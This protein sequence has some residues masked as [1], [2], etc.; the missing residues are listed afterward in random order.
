MSV[1]SPTRPLSKQQHAILRN[2]LELERRT[3][4]DGSGAGD[5]KPQR[6]AVRDLRGAVRKSPSD[7]VCFSRALRGLARRGIIILYNLRR[8]VS[9][10]PKA[11][12]VKIKT[13]D[14][15]TRATH[16]Q[17]T[18]EGRAVA[19]RDASP[20]VP[21]VVPLQ[22]EPACPPDSSPAALPSPVQR[23]CDWCDQEALPAGRLCANCRRDMYVVCNV[24]PR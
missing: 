9:A 16:I 3:R 18:E 14:K 23:K 12:K 4:Q 2:V 17:L 20:A 6:V 13:T 21:Q 5:P 15:H 1:I 8:G 19:S 7:R 24:S 22:S 11:G 10:G